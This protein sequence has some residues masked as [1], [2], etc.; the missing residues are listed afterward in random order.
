MIP[1]EGNSDLFRF[2]DPRQKRIYER[3]QRVGPGPARFYRDACQIMSGKPLLDTSTHLVAHLLRE[4]ESAL[5]NVLESVAE[6]SERLQKEKACQEKE[7]HKSKIL[8]VLNFLDIPETHAI[9]KA[10]LRLAGRSNQYGLSSRAHRNALRLPRPM[11]QDFLIFWENM[12]KIFDFVLEKWET[13]YLE[14]FSILDVLLTKLKPTRKDAKLLK[15]RLPNNFVLFNYF[16]QRNNNVEWLEPLRIEGFF[17]HPPEP[18]PEYETQTSGPAW[19]ASRWLTRMVEDVNVSEKVFEIALEI[20]ETQ[21][22]FVRLDIIDIALAIP[23]EIVKRA[24]TEKLVSKAKG[25]IRSPGGIFSPENLGALCVHFANGGWI[26]EAVDLARA[27]LEVLP[28][29]DAVKKTGEG[30]AFLQ[31]PEPRARLDIWHYE[32]IFEKRVPD[33]VKSGLEKTLDL[34]CD[35]LEKAVRFKLRPEESDGPVDYS[36]IWRPAIEEPELILPYGLADILVYGVRDAAES[37]MEEKASHILEVVEKRPYKIFKRIGL[38][39][40][41]KWPAAD[42]EGTANLITNP[43]IFNDHHLHHEFYHL[44][45]ERFCELPIHTRQEYLALIKKGRNVEKNRYLQEY[46]QDKQKAERSAQRWEYNKLWPIQKSLVGK[47]RERFNKL[48]SE[49]GELKQ[50]DVTFHIETFWGSNS[51]KSAEELSSMTIKDLVKYLKLWEPPRDEISADPEGLGRQLTGVVAMEPERFASQADVFRS[52]DPTY[53]RSLISGF[54]EAAKQNRTFQWPPVLDLCRWVIDQPREIPGRKSRYSHLDPGWVW[55]RLEIARLLVAGFESETQQITF[56][57]RDVAWQVLEP[58]TDDPD[59]TPAYEAEYAGH[60]D[61]KMDPATISI[62]TTRGE[63]IH[64]VVQYALWVRHNIKKQTDGKK[65]LERGFNE[66]KEVRDVLNKHL[67]TAHEPSLAIRAVYGWG[68]PWLVTLDEKWA[69]EK[70]SKIFPV[71]ESLADFRNAAWETYITFCKPYPKAFNI[72]REEYV[73]AVERIGP[74]LSKTRQLQAPEERLASHLMYFYAGDKIKLDEPKSLVKRFFEKAPDALRGFALHQVGEAMKNSEEKVVV[75]IM[76]R[77]QALWEWRL[78][79]ARASKDPKTHTE[80]LA[81]F[82]YWFISD[83]LETNWA[84]QQLRT[85]LELV[86]KVE[87][88]HKVVERLA[89]MSGEMPADA[90]ECLRLMV[91][92]DKERWAIHGWRDHPR[93]ILDTAIKSKDNKAREASEDLVN[94]LGA[95]GFL[96]YRDLLSKKSS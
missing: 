40:R 2:K 12:E 45:Y 94:R 34:L 17:E 66:M 95:R 46:Q 75:Q 70:V 53:V 69:T 11:D 39:L 26:E 30:E 77:I 61:M 23:V 92:G 32:Q 44:L 52:L 47:W 49:F 4:I 63:A 20:P 64:A 76:D 74:T 13:R 3:L 54:Q 22:V 83:R 79:E 50:P 41:R 10:W 57:L 80:E 96:Q 16:F 7:F 43:A 5:C 27:L 6:R 56:E 73:R 88:D 58:L 59:P 60:G 36:F 1:R 55:T 71:D 15:S 84:I 86:G 31:L 38:H 81:A 51:P 24:Q 82:G 68:V 62:N 78:K 33:L 35:L 89:E 67:D 14:Y 72:L 87:P 18:D 85:V 91:E 21:N 8:R 19:P 42:P 48:Q 29:P 65:R 25:W 28:D 9:A 37:L 93:I 90:V